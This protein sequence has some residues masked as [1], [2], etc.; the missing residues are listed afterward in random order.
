M[1]RVAAGVHLPTLLSARTSGKKSAEALAVNIHTAPRSIDH[2]QGH[3]L[4]QQVENHR[5]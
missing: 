4:G 2:E 1:K 5:I 3:A